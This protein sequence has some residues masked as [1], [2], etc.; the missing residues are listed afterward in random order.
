[1]YN[2]NIL[3]VCVLRDIFNYVKDDSFS[4]KKYA[5][6]YAKNQHFPSLS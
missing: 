1:M 6:L 4:V 2:F 5:Y 3:G